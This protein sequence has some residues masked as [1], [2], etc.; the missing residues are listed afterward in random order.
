MKPDEEQSGVERWAQSHPELETW[1]RANPDAR[2]V[3]RIKSVIRAINVKTSPELEAELAR[4]GGMALRMIREAPPQP[5][6]VRVA[7]EL[8]TVNLKLRAIIDLIQAPDFEETR[9]TMIRSLTDLDFRRFLPSWLR[10]KVPSERGVI[11]APGSAIEILIDQF[12]R[13]VAEHAAAKLRAE[14]VA[15]LEILDRTMGERARLLGETND[16]DSKTNGADPHVVV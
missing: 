13:A 9:E 11:T 16:T 10:D 2:L 12:A 15:H 4:L 5:A 6:P 3:V 1:V 8:E 7:N 14:K